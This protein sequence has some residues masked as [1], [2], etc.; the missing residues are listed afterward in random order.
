MR[1]FMEYYSFY[2]ILIYF[3][4]TVVKMCMKT[5]EKDII[6]YFAKAMIIVPILVHMFF[7]KM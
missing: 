5:E 4:Y 2:V 7:S 6:R 1:I 3:V